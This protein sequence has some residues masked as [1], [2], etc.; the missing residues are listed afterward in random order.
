MKHESKRESLQFHRMKRA[1]EERR[2]ERTLA[3]EKT[4]VQQAKKQS[5]IE[6]ARAKE[7]EA[8]LAARKEDNEVLRDAIRAKLSGRKG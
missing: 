3:N 8:R 4:L 5:K 7:M 6:E 1:E 2:F